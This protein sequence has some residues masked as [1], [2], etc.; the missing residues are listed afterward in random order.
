MKLVRKKKWSCSKV[1]SGLEEGLNSTQIEIKK[2]YRKKAIIHHPD[3]NPNDPLAAQKFQEIGEAYQVLSDSNLRKRYDL[4]GKE[5]AVPKEGFEDP[6]EFFATIFG[7]EAFV[8]YIGELTMLKELTKSAEIH[9]QYESKEAEDIDETTNT[10]SSGAA[11]A[12]NADANEN[13][14]KQNLLAISLSE[15]DFEKDVNE[16]LSSNEFK[17]LTSEELEL[18]KQEFIKQKKKELEIKKQEELDKYNEQIRKEKLEREKKLAQTLITKIS[19][20]TETDK[21]DDVTK[22]FINIISENANELKMESFGIEILHTIG[23]IYYNKGDIFMKNHKF[24][25]IGGMWGSMKLKMNVVGDTFRTISSALDAQKTLEELD[26]LKE[27]REKLLQ[28]QQNLGNNGNIDS[29]TKPETSQTIGKDTKDTK[30]EE[31]EEEEKIPTEEEIAELEQYLI[32]QILASAWNASR[33]EISST[34]KNVCDLILE[35][36]TVD[37]NKRKERAMALKYMGQVFMSVERTKSE[38]EEVRVFEEL[39]ADATTRKNRKKHE[40]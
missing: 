24:L 17:N 39:V 18:K 36:K 34:L 14:K 26:R 19:L 38:D 16:K 11:T 5:D 13:I 8:D 30:E 32:G 37:I 40:K 1:P 35:D 10:T 3:K 6:N 20:W 2:A 12:T 7:G 31:E 9:S 21:K 23:N 33:F 25:G 29:K 15:Y 27:K 4:Y 22:S 28:K